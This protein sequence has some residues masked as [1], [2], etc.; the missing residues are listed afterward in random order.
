MTEYDR[1]PA[2]RAAVEQAR[3]A[4]NERDDTWTDVL[5]FYA[6]ERGPGDG[7]RE[8]AEADIRRMIREEIEGVRR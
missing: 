1:I 2:E 4:K 5:R 3:E 8:W 6:R 7:A